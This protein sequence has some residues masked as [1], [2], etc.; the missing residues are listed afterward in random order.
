MQCRHRKDKHWVMQHSGTSGMQR[1]MGKS[2]YTSGFAHLTSCYLFSRNIFSVQGEQRGNTRG[3][4]I[5]VTVPY[6]LLDRGYTNQVCLDFSTVVVE[7]MKLRY[8]DKQPQIEWQAGDVRDMTGIIETKSV[9]VAFDKSTLDP[10]IYG[11][12]WSPPDDVLGNTARYMAEVGNTDLQNKVL[13]VLKDDGVFLCITFRQPHFV[14]PIINRANE[15]E[16]AVEVMGD[17]GSLQYFGFVL[18][19]VK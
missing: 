18:R 6:D 16:V 10:M 9:D 13:R 2:Q 12:P 17:R 4:C 19:K 8:S 11:N 1:L 7:S 14:K 5:W 15:W 3:Y